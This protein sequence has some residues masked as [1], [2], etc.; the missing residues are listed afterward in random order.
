MEH[1]QEMMETS[2]DEIRRYFVVGFALAHYAKKLVMSRVASR[3]FVPK[4]D[5]HPLTPRRHHFISA[6]IPWNML[7][8]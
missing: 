8:A 2:L 1:A 5:P 6:Q 3:L 4:L 7:D